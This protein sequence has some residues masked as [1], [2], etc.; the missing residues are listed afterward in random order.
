MKTEIETVLS[1]IEAAA[2]DASV[3]RGN[4]PMGKHIRQGDVMLT[5][6]SD[7]T[8]HGAVLA[9]GESVQI[10]VGQNVGARHVMTG[11]KGVTVFAPATLSPLVGPVIVVGRGAKGLLTHPEHRHFEI[12]CGTYAVTFQRDYMQEEI[13]RVQD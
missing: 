13:A 11:G 4:I 2:P 12:P 8:P 7:E 10:A 5:R 9:E 3:W 6:V 1:G